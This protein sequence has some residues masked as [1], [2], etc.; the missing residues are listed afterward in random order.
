[1]SLGNSHAVVLVVAVVRAVEPFIEPL[2]WYPFGVATADD[3]G[4]AFSMIFIETKRMRGKRPDGV[5]R[6]RHLPK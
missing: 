5:V 1:M 6:G 3:S 2:V 4:R